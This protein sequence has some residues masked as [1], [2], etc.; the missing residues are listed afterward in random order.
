MMLRRTWKFR[1]LE[2]EKLIRRQK[3]FRPRVC[4][5][6]YG[7]VQ[8]EGYWLSNARSPTCAYS[9]PTFLAVHTISS[10]IWID[11]CTEFT[12]YSTFK[13]PFCTTNL[14]LRV[15]CSLSPL[16][17]QARCTAST[18][19]PRPYPVHSSSREHR[20]ALSHIQSSTEG[21]IRVETKPR[22]P[23]HCVLGSRSSKQTPHP[24]HV[25]SQES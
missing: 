14:R 2:A 17:P 9:S 11:L 4:P 15:S 5:A 12:I 20:S 1:G 22:S 23:G 18:P 10:R 8:F 25:V 3:L 7:R 13:V 6:N 21:G 19:G 24:N 16:Q